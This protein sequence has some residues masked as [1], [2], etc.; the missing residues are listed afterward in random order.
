MDAF[1]GLLDL[2]KNQF[3]KFTGIFEKMQ[4]E[5]NAAL[6]SSRKEAI[7]RSEQGRKAQEQEIGTLKKSVNNQQSENSALKEIYGEAQLTSSSIQN[8]LMQCR[9]DVKQELVYRAKAEGYQK[10][11]TSTQEKLGNGVVTQ[12]HFISSVENQLKKHPIDIEGIQAQLDNKYP[13][14]APIPPLSDAVR[15]FK[16]KAVEDAKALEIAAAGG[17]SNIKAKK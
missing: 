17:K 12:E 1:T 4:T 14:P 10:A 2:T 11:V 3:D 6:E 16:I 9:S 5:S 15:E 13:N 8:S 7:Q